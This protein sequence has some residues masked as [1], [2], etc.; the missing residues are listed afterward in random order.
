MVRHLLALI[1][2]FTAHGSLLTTKACDACGGGLNLTGWGLMPNLRQHFVGLR[3][4][5]AAFRTLAPEHPASRETYWQTTLTGRAALSPRWQLMA[6]VPLARHTY[7][8]P[9]QPFTMLVGQ[10]DISV[11]AGYALVNTLDSTAT[12][13]HWLQLSAGAKLPTGHWENTP[14]DGAP[15]PFPANFQLGSGSWDALAGLT[16]RVGGRRWGT[17]TD[18]QA[19]ITTPN[20]E[21][22]QFGHSFRANVA[23]FRVIRVANPN[24]D[25]GVPWI[26]QPHAG[27]SGDY[28]TA[29]RSHNITRTRTGGHNVWATAGAELFTGRVGAGVRV[30]LPLLNRPAYGTIAPQPQAMAQVLW[31]F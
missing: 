31:F 24:P 22:Y 8:V 26:V 18:A 20:A 17:Q 1:L 12:A 15:L 28:A 27:L 9:N 25:A 23:V 6:S 3:L 16:Y 14:E 10:R 2:L 5:R 4:E 21:A 13:R 29:D 19:R 7:E 11:M 30:S